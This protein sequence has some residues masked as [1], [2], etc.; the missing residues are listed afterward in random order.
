M[1]ARSPGSKRGPACGRASATLCAASATSSARPCNRLASCMTAC[2]SR[3]PTA[4][5][6]WIASLSAAARPAASASHAAFRRDTLL[7]ADS[8]ARA[9][10]IRCVVPGLQSAVGSF[11]AGAFTAWRSALARASTS[12]GATNG[13][14]AGLRARSALSAAK[15][16]KRPA[17][18][19]L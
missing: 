2:S 10:S 9:A 13:G 14:A 18:S 15:A 17:T 11:A 6:A 3:K 4:V 5:H 19:E 1:E 12:A 8:A 7:G 16:T